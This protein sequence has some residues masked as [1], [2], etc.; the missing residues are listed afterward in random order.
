LITYNNLPENAQTEFVEMPKPQNLGSSTNLK[1]AKKQTTKMVKRA[2]GHL[3]DDGGME[4]AEVDLS[5]S[6][7]NLPWKYNAHDS[8]PNCVSAVQDQG[9]CG[10]CYAF[11][12]ATSLS[13]RQC[14]YLTKLAS[15][16]PGAEAP[17]G[18]EEL[19]PQPL[20]SCGSQLSIQGGNGCGHSFTYG[21]DGGNGGMAMQ[22]I[23]TYGLDRADSYPYV[24][25]G[26][27]AA[28]HFDLLGEYVPDCDT[29][30]AVT[31]KEDNVFLYDVKKS[32]QETQIKAAI[33]SEGAVYVGF[34][35]YEDIWNMDPNQVYVPD[36]ST[37]VQGGH[38]VTAF[39]WGVANGVKYWHLRNSWG[40]AWGTNGNFRMLRG[41]GIIESAYYGSVD[42]AVVNPIDTSGTLPECVIA[43]GYWF[44]NVDPGV[45]E[46][47]GSCYFAGRNDCDVTVKMWGV[48]WGL[49]CYQSYSL[50]P[51]QTVLYNAPCDLDLR[52]TTS[53]LSPAFTGPPVTFPNN[54]VY[55]AGTETEYHGP[56]VEPTYIPTTEP[57]PDPT[58][59]T[60]IPPSP[61]PPT[62]NPTNFP[63]LFPTSSPTY[64]AA[65]AIE[66]IGDGFCDH[67]NNNHAC[68]YDGGDCCES[69]CQSTVYTCPSGQGF[70][71]CID[72]SATTSAVAE[73][74][75]DPQGV[76]ANLGYQCATLTSPLSV[77][78]DFDYHAVDSSYPV[79]SFV[80]TFCPLSC[81]SCTAAVGEYD[82]H[83]SLQPTN[84]PTAEACV[85][86]WRGDGHCDPINNAVQCAY[87][88][89]D[90]CESSC[91]DVI[92]SHEGFSCGQG[93]GYDCVDPDNSGSG[94]GVSGGSATASAQAVVPNLKVQ[95][96]ATAQASASL[97]AVP[98][99]ASAS[100][101]GVQASGGAKVGVGAAMKQVRNLKGAVNLK[102]KGA[103]NLKGSAKVEMKKQSKFLEAQALTLVQGQGQGK[104]TAQTQPQGLAAASNLIHPSVLTNQPASNIA[105]SD[106]AAVPVEPLHAAS[107]APLQVTSAQ[108]KSG[109]AG[110]EG[111]KGGSASTSAL[112][113]EEMTVIGSRAIRGRSVLNRI[114]DGHGAAYVPTTLVGVLALVSATAALAVGG[115]TVARRRGGYQK[116]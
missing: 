47:Y 105:V 100:L 60:P 96:P 36:K 14:I 42:P 19:G 23:A 83:P 95:A 16:S 87:D 89:G 48:G 86:A 44:A 56:T 5:E 91:N 32:K 13:E 110:G 41:D 26:G 88:G 25:G 78:C 34:T 109:A 58:P 33:L 11:A 55:L 46:A 111:A 6:A 75:D 28:D 22:Y 97:E 70:V 57:T 76:V 30:K 17:T 66:Y 54:P 64:M 73:C 62:N 72:P 59:P 21:C 35:V 2:L 106:Y 68:D 31:D 99:K 50:K 27:D 43:S 93:S 24:S 94:G 85:D 40:S 29:Q 108:Q 107:S 103:V 113:Q 7:T 104:G 15:E 101:K 71:N 4:E 84:K 52:A 79:A 10:S 102:V 116:V 90:C 9:A 92:T 114:L 115:R 12:T 38:A 18:V 77:G 65:C 74:V 61:P 53:P 63:S 112:L 80:H 67:D 51:G 69:S 45:F 82:L 1:G 49:S 81:G 8:Y 37:P 39:G 98:A 3:F 20:V